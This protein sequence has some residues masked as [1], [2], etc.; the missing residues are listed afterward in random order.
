M[1]YECGGKILQAALDAYWKGQ[2]AGVLLARDEE[3]IDRSGTSLRIAL[4]QSFTQ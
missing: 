1:R 2:S 3:T 4:T